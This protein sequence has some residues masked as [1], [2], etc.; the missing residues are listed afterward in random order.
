M[1]C[2]V[3]ILVFAL[4]STPSRKWVV[5]CD[6]ISSRQSLEYTLSS[7]G[8]I[9]KGFQGE[10]GT[11]VWISEE[12]PF[13]KVSLIAGCDARVLIEACRRIRSH[14]ILL[15]FGSLDCHTDLDG[16]GAG[17]NLAR[18]VAV[19]H[20]DCLGCSIAV[21]THSDRRRPL[22]DLAE[23][24]P[25]PRN[26]DLDLAQMVVLRCHLVDLR[27]SW[28][29]LVDSVEQELCRSLLQRLDDAVEVAVPGW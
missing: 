26:C 13:E 14:G 3:L 6:R 5:P 19:A 29:S 23:Y 9:S 15:A 20:I 10:L 24:N 28:D 8:G 16:P 25:M 27:A 4:S 1:F 18:N 17:V 12:H 21:G 11:Y 7:C 2:V 22:L